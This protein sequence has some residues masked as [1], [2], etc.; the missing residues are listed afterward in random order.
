MCSI[1]SVMYQIEEINTFNTKKRFDTFWHN[2]SAG[3]SAIKMLVKLT[4][5]FLIQ[6][7]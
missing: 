6:G 1:L 3:K 2:N 5:D 4:P 7:Q